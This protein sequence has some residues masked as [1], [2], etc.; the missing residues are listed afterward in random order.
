MR[1]RKI[2][3]G[4]IILNIN[5]SIIRNLKFSDKSKY[6]SDFKSLPF[7]VV[8]SLDDPEEKLSI[9]NDIVLEYINTHEPT[10]RTK[11]KNSRA[12]WMPDVDIKLL[13]NSCHEA[14]SKPF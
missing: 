9:F 10:K 4:Y 12:P 11:I 7:S 14:R 2:T 5:R 8:F 1:T 13:W 6:I 3:K